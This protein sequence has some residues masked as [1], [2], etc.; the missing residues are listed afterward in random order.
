MANLSV[1]VLS[2]IFP[3]RPGSGEPGFVWEQVRTLSAH[4]RMSVIAPVPWVPPLITPRRHLGLSRLPRQQDWSGTPVWRPRYPL[5]PRRALFSLLP[6]AYLTAIGRTVEREARPADLI[7]AHFAYPDGVAAAWLALRLAK[8][9]VLTVHGSDLNDYGR[10]TPLRIQLTWAL[11]RASAVIGGSR[12]LALA[13]ARLGAPADRVHVVPPLVDTRIFFPRDKHASRRALRLPDDSPMVLFVGRLDPVKAVPDLLKAASSLPL[14]KAKC[15][16]A[17]VGDGPERRRLHQLAEQLGIAGRVRFMG[18]TAHDQIPLW[19]SAADVLVLPSTSEG[20]GLVLAESIACGRPVV[21]TR[22]GG[23]E[24]IVTSEFGR[25]VPCNRPD[26]LGEAIAGVLVSS[27]S[28][29]AERL[30]AQAR[31]QWSAECVA[32]RIMDIYRDCLV[33]RDG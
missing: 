23:P 26:A 10:H 6:F 27:D 21:A 25:L 2:H 5:L 31:E 28:F 11:R 17:L 29:R 22:C 7:H 3:A 33:G 15:H 19:M 4:C 14:S 18:A 30:A 1:A 16:L 9:L 13:A 12:S 32:G 8:P 20:F 24:D